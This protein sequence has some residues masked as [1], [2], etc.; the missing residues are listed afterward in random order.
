MGNETPKNVGKDE[1]KDKGRKSFQEETT[2]E[3]D[4][5]GKAAG[6]FEVEKRKNVGENSRLMPQPSW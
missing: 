5:E 3:P 1:I 2:S 6:K 4:I